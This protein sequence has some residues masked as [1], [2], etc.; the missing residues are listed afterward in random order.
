MKLPYRRLFSVSG[1]FN[2]SSG[3]TDGS[4]QLAAI[5]DIQCEYAEEK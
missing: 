1:N 5:V 3:N 2:A 4:S